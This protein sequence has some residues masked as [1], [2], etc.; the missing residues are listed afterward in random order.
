LIAQ[1]ANEITQTKAEIIKD[2]EVEKV[3]SQNLVAV[4][5]NKQQ[6]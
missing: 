5:K 1:G 4:C 6:A 2:V 3:S